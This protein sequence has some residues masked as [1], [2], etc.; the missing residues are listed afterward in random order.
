MNETEKN[1]VR[2]RITNGV[3]GIYT[4]VTNGGESLSCRVRGAIRIPGADSGSR[5]AGAYNTAARLDRP[6]CGDIV[7]AER[8]AD[9]RS[10]AADG[11]GGVITAI[12]ERRNA[13]IRPPLANIDYIF[14]AFAAAKPAPVLMTVDKLLSIAEYNKI[15]PVIVIGKCELDRAA[16][17]HA[18]D[19]YR[20]AGY[21]V[22]PLSC[23]TGEGIAEFSAFIGEKLPGCVAAF[24]GA[25]GVGKSTLLNALFPEL[26]LRTGG[27]S[28]KIG[29][30]RHTTRSCSLFALPGGGYIADTPGFS[31][32]DF[33]SFDFFGLDDLADTMR[34]FR[35]YYGGCRYADCTHT[36]EEGCAVLGAVEDGA[37]ARE[38]HESYLSMYAA[39]KAKPF[40]GKGK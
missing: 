16:A 23:A 34:E 39:L 6:L 25:S 31:L 10:G 4:V 18:A 11:S 13:L 35:P 32:L 36:K 14:A 9:A 33:E 2:G 3:G 37:I 20:R 38:R 27:V 40:W 1:T 29:R 5:T 17:A 28:E 15:E 26:A 24:A 22:F 30:G 7:T 8:G 19:I 21:A 12:H